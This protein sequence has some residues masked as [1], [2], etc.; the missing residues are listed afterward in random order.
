MS[1]TN[2]SSGRTVGDTLRVNVAVATSSGA[3]VD[4]DVTVLVG[5]PAGAVRRYVSTSTG[6]TGIEHLATGTYRLSVISTGPGDYVYVA[7]STG[8]V[9]QSTYGRWAVAPAPVST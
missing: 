8:L 5:P 2:T 6:S 1:P 4:S 3:P 9:T 7:R